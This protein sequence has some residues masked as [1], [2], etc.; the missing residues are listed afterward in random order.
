MKSHRRSHTLNVD[1]GDGEPTARVVQPQVF[2]EGSG[3]ATER[4]LEP[5]AEMPRAQPCSLG[6]SLNGQVLSQMTNY[7]GSQIRETICG[8]NLELQRFRNIVLA[9]PTASDTP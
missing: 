5:A 1:V 3:G 7:P 8:L 2:Y 9:R 4:M 6:Q